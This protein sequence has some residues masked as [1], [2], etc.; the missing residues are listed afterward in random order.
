M[1]GRVGVS[2][3]VCSSYWIFSRGVHIGVGN[4]FWYLVLPDLFPSVS[5][6][7]ETVPEVDPLRRPVKDWL[8]FV[9]FCGGY[10]SISPIVEEIFPK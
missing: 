4:K 9:T 6:S 2:L 3:K 10:N 7:T 5:V 1:C 8:G